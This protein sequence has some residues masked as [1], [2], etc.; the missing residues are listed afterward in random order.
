MFLKL[1]FLCCYIARNNVYCFLQQYIAMNLL[2][3][4][5]EKLNKL[6]F[7]YEKQWFWTSKF[8]ANLRVLKH[9]FLLF[10][11]LKWNYGHAA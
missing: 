6:Q 8:V 1:I 5:L 11:F 3:K 9:I 10:F 7:L 2:A 4:L